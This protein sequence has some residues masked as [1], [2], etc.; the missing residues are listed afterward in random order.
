MESDFFNLEKL[1]NLSKLQLSYTEETEAKQDLFNIIEFVK[2]IADLNLQ[3]SSLSMDF[4]VSS[5]Q[6]RDDSEEKN[7]ISG[8]SSLS[9]FENEMVIAPKIHDEGF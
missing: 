4:K 3:N 2:R 6:T 5:F 9:F 8:R 1:L 7:I